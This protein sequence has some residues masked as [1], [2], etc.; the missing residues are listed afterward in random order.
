MVGASSRDIRQSGTFDVQGGPL[1]GATTQ[2]ETATLAGDATLAANQVGYTG[3]G[4]V[5]GFQKAGAAASFKIN[6]AEAGQ[7]NV[8]LRYASTLRPGEQNTPRTLS[9]YANGAKIG[10]TTLPNLANWDMWDFKTEIVPLNAGDN[11]ITYQ[12]D[13]GDSGDIHL[14]AIMVAKTGEPAPIP[15]NTSQAPGAPT[16]AATPADTGSTSTN[17]WIPILLSALVVLVVVVIVVRWRL[18]STR[19]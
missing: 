2:A 13:A 8:T 5:S 6:V 1:A 15:A 14:D 12:Y 19:K 18:R 7:H 3:T 4:F 17:L 16:I 10:Q 11:T 9:L